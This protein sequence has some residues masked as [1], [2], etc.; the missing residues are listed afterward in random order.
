MAAL[1]YFGGGLYGGA[2]TT[3]WQ[4]NPTTNATLQEYSLKNIW[5]SKTEIAALPT[6]V[7]AWDV[8]KKYADQA[9]GA[10]E[11]SNQ[12]SRANVQ[13]LAAALVYARTGDQVALKHVQYAGP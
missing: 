7:T 2:R 12:D 8:V 4:C 6:S 1:L 11:P 13:C 10:A 5:L 3:K 9:T